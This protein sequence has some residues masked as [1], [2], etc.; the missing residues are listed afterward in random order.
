[1]EISLSS[2]PMYTMG[3]YLLPEEVHHKIDSARA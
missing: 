3:I 1:M 2:P